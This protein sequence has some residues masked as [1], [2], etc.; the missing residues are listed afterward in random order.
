VARHGAGVGADATG[1]AAAGA[2]QARGAKGAPRLCQASPS[3]AARRGAGVGAEATGCAAAG[4][5][6]ACGV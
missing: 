1:C 2:P 4:A 5:S 3:A 6:Q